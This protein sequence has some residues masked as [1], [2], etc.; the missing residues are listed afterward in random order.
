M[1][2]EREENH[3][4]LEWLEAGI[5]DGSI[6]FIAKETPDNRPRMLVKWPDGQA[7][8]LFI[9]NPLGKPK[10]RYLTYEP[11][12]KFNPAFGFKQELTREAFD[13]L[14]GIADEWCLSANTELERFI[15]EQA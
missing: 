12:Y 2:I 3:G 7:E 10:H 4:T 14:R 9:L 11:F 15:A 5:H 1:K 13:R 8:R 6:Q